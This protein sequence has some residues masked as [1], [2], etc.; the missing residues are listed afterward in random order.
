MYSVP[1][2]TIV[3]LA[4]PATLNDLGGGEETPI[5]PKRRR[6]SRL[7]T[8][9]GRSPSPMFCIAV[10]ST[11]QSKYWNNPGGWRGIVRFLKDAGYRVVCIDLKP[12]HGT[13]LIWNHSPTGLLGICLSLLAYRWRFAVHERILTEFDHMWYTVFLQQSQISSMYRFGA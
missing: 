11:K 13:E 2:L 9:R 6:A 10:Q 1:L 5:R 7:R 4:V 12:T 3:S 8:I